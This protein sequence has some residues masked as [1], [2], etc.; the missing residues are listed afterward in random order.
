[1]AWNGCLTLIVNRM[2]STIILVRSWFSSWFYTLHSMTSN[3]SGMSS[4]RQENDE[5][6][7]NGLR[8]IGTLSF[9]ALAWS[10]KLQLEA[11]PEL[12]KL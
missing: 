8:L 4:P 12:F 10:F 6:N 7:D 11:G 2:H 1:M 3:F 5:C 9:Q